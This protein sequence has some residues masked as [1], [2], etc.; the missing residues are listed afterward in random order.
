MPDYTSDSPKSDYATY[1]PDNRVWRARRRS[2]Y[3]CV[4]A[5][6][7]CVAFWAVAIYMGVVAV[8]K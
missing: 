5:V 2:R 7:F 4:S 6:L 1:R 8:W 3:G